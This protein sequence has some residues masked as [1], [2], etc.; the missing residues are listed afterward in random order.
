VKYELIY[1]QGEL[2]EYSYIGSMISHSEAQDETQDRHATLGCFATFKN[3]NSSSI[4]ALISKHFA[5]YVGNE[6]FDKDNRLLGRVIPETRDQGFYDIAAAETVD[7]R[8]LNLDTF[9]RN[10]KGEV[11]RASLIKKMDNLQV[12]IHYQVCP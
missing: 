9:F 8:V 3:S 6:I 4:C 11:K 2:E 5:K 12:R 10:Y 1:I 7:K